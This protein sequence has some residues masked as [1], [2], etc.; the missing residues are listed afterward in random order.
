MRPSVLETD[1]ADIDI[2]LLEDAVVGEKS[3]DVVADF[4][5]R[6]AEGIDVG[7]QLGRKVLMH[8]ARTDIG[9]MHAAAGGPLVEHHQLLALLEAPQRRRQRA[10]IQGLGGDVEEMR[11]KAADLGI[12]HAD[13]LARLGTVTPTSF[14]TASE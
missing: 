14:S 1:H 13:E 6:V 10:D 2:A 12:E 4:E 8:A 9:G 7:D 5:E 11:Q 3:L